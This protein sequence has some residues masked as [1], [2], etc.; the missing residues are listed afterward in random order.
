MFRASLFSFVFVFA[1][2]GNKV[3]T[4]VVDEN[5]VEQKKEDCIC[6]LDY[7]PVCGCNGKTYGNACAAECHGITKYTPG[8]CK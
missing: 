1:S 5:C 6:T 8:E 2:C 7:T 3:P 4:N